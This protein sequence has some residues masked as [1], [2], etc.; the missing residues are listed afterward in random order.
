MSEVALQKAIITAL[1]QLGEWVI[2]TGVSKKRGKRG[3]NSGES[4]MPDLCLPELGWL[5]VKLPGEELSP[6]QVAWH[7]KAKRHGVRVAVV[8]SVWAAVSTRGRWRRA[9]AKR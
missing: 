2:R 9:Q 6:K 7:E 3:T 4:G 8:D 5:E 1:E